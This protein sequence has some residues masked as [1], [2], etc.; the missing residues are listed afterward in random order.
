MLKATVDNIVYLGED[1]LVIEAMTGLKRTKA[2]YQITDNGL[3]V[4]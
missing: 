3:V 4:G 2:S 1:E